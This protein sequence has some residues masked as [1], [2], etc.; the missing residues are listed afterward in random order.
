MPTTK[1]RV[2]VTL[3]PEAYEVLQGM[4]RLGHT[5]PGR[6]LSELAQPVLPVLKR[7]V[8]ASQDFAAWQASMRAEMGG[9]YQEVSQG[10]DLAIK[11]MEEGRRAADGSVP[12]HVLQSVSSPQTAPVG[13]GAAG[14]AHRAGPGS[15]AAG[16]AP[17]GV[18]R[19]P[20]TNR[21]VKLPRSSVKSKA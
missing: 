19:T 1:P 20:H 13:R 15:G 9:M 17:L 16:G 14:R 8:E 5:T 4:A 18:S 3:E 12:A 10:I 11:A 2:W 7:L 6:V 21:G